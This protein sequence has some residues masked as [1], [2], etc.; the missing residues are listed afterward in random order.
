MATSHGTAEPGADDDGV[1]LPSVRFGRCHVPSAPL[2]LKLQSLGCPLSSPPVASRRDADRQSPR[3]QREKVTYRRWGAVTTVS[4]LKRHQRL[5]LRAVFA[6]GNMTTIAIRPLT[7]TTRIRVAR[8]ST[9]SAL[10]TYLGER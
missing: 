4:E 6:L 3:R 5:R 10:L 2:Y 1:V 9:T 7:W 8:C